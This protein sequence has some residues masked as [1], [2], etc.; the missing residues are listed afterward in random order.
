MEQV[1]HQMKISIKQSV[2]FFFWQ[3]ILDTCD[4]SAMY[5]ELQMLYLSCGIML[6]VECEIKIKTN[7]NDW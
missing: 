1:E 4:K 6:C 5:I 7:I 2:D 3:G